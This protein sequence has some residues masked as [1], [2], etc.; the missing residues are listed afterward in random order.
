MGANSTLDV[1]P[2]LRDAATQAGKVRGSLNDC[3]CGLLLQTALLGGDGGGGLFKVH[4]MG[5]RVCACVRAC[6][7]AMI[8]VVGSLRHLLI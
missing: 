8:V 3:C 1:P 5:C 4:G 6:D 2:G 7:C